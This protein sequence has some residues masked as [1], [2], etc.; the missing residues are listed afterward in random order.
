MPSNYLHRDNFSRARARAL[1]TQRHVCWA[2]SRCRKAFEGNF[3]RRRGNVG[4]RRDVK[5]IA[6]MRS[7]KLRA[8]LRQ[9]GVER[10]S[11]PRF[12][13]CRGVSVCITIFSRQNGSGRQIACARDWMQQQP[14]SRK[15]ISRKTGPEVFDADSPGWDYGWNFCV[16]LT[17]ATGFNRIPIILS[18]RKQ[19]GPKEYR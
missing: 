18:V 5:F 17:R 2:R 10:T 4:L 11:S 8:L 13:N 16:I 1:D 3:E 7:R 9:Y 19:R 15:S 12:R 14:K 6:T